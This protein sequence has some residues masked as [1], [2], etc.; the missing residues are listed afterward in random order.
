MSYDKYIWQIGEVITAAKL[1]HIE[2]GIAAI[3]TVQY[4]IEGAPLPGS[5][6]VFKAANNAVK[7]G[8]TGIMTGLDGSKHCYIVTISKPSE[9]EGNQEFVTL[10]VDSNS[11]VM[12]N[13]WV[14][15]AENEGFVIKS[16]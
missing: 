2:D 6:V 1:N 15:S 14:Y 13:K 12:V 16:Q 10:T 4:T 5:P 11:Q 9:G 3:G 8:D 7:A